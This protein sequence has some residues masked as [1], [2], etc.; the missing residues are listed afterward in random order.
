MWPIR[1][2]GGSNPET[3]V[4]A[5]A[6]TAIAAGK[7]VYINGSG[8]MALADAT[9]EGKEVVGFTKTAT[10]SGAVGT[11]FTVGVIPSQTGLTIGADQF[12]TT[13]PG[14][15]GPVPSTTGNVAQKVGVATSA[16]EIVFGI[17]TPITL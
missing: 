2:A 14:L 8:Q 10:L 17:Y 11:Y 7:L 3:G 5:V 16:T 13:T 15:A 6:A 12:M 4:S 9:A 1:N